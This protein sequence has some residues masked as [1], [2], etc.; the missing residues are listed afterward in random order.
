M[1]SSGLRCL[2]LS[3]SSTN[4]TSTS[5]VKLLTADGSTLSCSGSRIIPLRFGTCSFELLFQLAPVSVLILGA[6][7]LHHH[8]LLLEVANQK[9]FSSSSPS[10]CLTSSPLPSFLSGLISSPPQ[11]VSQTFSGFATSPP[12]HQICHHLLMHAGPPVFSKACHLDPDKLAVAKA[13]FSA[14]EKAGII[15]CSTLP[16]SSPLHMVKK[17]DG[18]WRP[19]GNYKCLNTATIPD[20]YHLPKVADFTSRISGSTVFSK[21]DLQKGYYQVPVA[22]EVLDSAFARAKD[23]L[24]P[25]RNSSILVLMLRCLEQWMLPILTWVQFS[26]SAWTVPGLRYPSTPESFQMLR[27]NTPPSTVNSWLPTL[28][29]GIFTLC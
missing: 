24:S 10:V 6:D 12:C 9:V 1:V 17:K 18:G 15:H 29:S 2:R 5:G 26:S 14:V 4:S 22:P 19:C 23:L 7:F 21:L 28:F 27:R 13:E 16:W 20:W 3:F 8:N 11:S 25:S